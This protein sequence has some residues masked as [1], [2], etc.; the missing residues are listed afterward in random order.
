MARRER[1]RS[2]RSGSAKTVGQLG[3]SRSPGHQPEQLSGPRARIGQVVDHS[4]CETEPSNTL[5]RGGGTPSYI[6]ESQ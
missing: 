4:Q 6:Q 3:S 1:A 2:Q 5:A